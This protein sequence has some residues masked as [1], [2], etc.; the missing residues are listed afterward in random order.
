MNLYGFKASLVYR[1]SSRTA[2][3]TQRNSAS[4]KQRNKQNKPQNKQKPNNNEI[5]FPRREGNK[6]QIKCAH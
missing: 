3:T 2:R 1:V 4:K 5:K 6:S